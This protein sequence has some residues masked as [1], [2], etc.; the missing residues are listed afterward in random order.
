M[1]RIYTNEAVLLIA[2]LLLAAAVAF[3]WA[4]N[5]NTPG[6]AGTAPERQ[7]AAAGLIPDWRSLGAQT[8][9]ERCASCHAEGQGTRRVPPLRGAPLRLFGAEGGRSYLIDFLLYGSESGHGRHPAYADRVS[10]DQAAAALNHMLTAWGNAELLPEGWRPYEAEEVAGHR[11]QALTPA[12]VH[13]RRP[14]AGPG[15]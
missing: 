15:R 9:E 5:R 6:P 4:R 14:Q 13:A 3:A 10:D 1:R 12:Q 2:G 7:S 8:Y 11:Q